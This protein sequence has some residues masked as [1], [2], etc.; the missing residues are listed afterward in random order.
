LWREY[1]H[2]GIID[3][4]RDWNKWFKCSDIDPTILPS[5]VVNRSRKKGYALLFARRIFWRPIKTFKL[6]RTFG[7]YMKWT[8]IWTLLASPFRRRTLTRKPELTARMLDIGLEEPDR[9]TISHS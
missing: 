1:I 9:R 3:D 2:R 6:I 5:E 4:E 7:R 8:D